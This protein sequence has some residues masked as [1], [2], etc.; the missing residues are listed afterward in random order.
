MICKHDICPMVVNIAIGTNDVGIQNFKLMKMRENYIDFWIMHLLV[1][2]RGSRGPSTVTLIALL[3][4]ANCGG[5]V[6]TIIVKVKL[7][8]G[9]YKNNFFY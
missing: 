5:L 2:E 3:Y 1:F 7:L 9:K 8:P 6:D 4:V